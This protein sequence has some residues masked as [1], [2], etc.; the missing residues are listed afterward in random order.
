M[1]MPYTM[2]NTKSADALMNTPVV[3]YGTRLR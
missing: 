3:G 2:V 1:A